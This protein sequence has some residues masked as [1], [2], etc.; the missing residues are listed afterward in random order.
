LG[1]THCLY[2]SSITYMHAP[3]H[4]HLC[5][6]TCRYTQAHAH[7]SMHA[8]SYINNPKLIQNHTSRA[9]LIMRDA[10]HIFLSEWEW[11]KRTL[12]VLNVCSWR[13]CWPMHSRT[14]QVEW[15]ITDILE[16]KCQLSGR[17]DI[18]PALKGEASEEPADAFSRTQHTWEEPKPG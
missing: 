14:V 4:A 5:L 1:C 15:L 17:N 2:S 18:L 11:Y 8:C 3:T 10:T 12:L 16:V 7:V 9:S 6:H 13:I